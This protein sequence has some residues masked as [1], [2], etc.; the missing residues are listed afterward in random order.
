MGI[1]SNK[2][3]KMQSQGLVGVNEMEMTLRTVSRSILE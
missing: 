3:P 1:T 2:K